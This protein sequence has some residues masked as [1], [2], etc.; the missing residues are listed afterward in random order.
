MLS[1]IYVGIGGFIGAVFRF[2]LSSTI[3][4]SSRFPLGTLGVN[5]L[6]AFTLSF[7]TYS[8][9]KAFALPEPSRLFLTVGLLGA[10]T[11][12]STFSLESF[13]LLEEQQNLLFIANLA[14][15]NILCLTGIYLGKIASALL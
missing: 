14:L 3:Q 4:G 5:I 12:M 15:N 13:K 10:F 8:S 2:L 1:I 7:I 9:E 11:T 6:G